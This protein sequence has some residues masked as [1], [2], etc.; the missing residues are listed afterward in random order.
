MKERNITL[1][2]CDKR[3]CQ[4]KPTDLRLMCMPTWRYTTNKMNQSHQGGQRTHKTTQHL[5]TRDDSNK[6]TILDMAEP[7][8]SALFDHNML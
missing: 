5:H 7:D 1:Y 6:D 8:R 4:K 3:K 2:T